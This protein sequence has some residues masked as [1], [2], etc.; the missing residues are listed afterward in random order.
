MP[1]QVSGLVLVYLKTKVSVHWVVLSLNPQVGQTISTQ[2]KIV[3]L[4]NTDDSSCT[5]RAFYLVN[6]ML[7][8]MI[9][10][11]IADT[12]LKYVNSRNKTALIKPI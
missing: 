4:K 3:F 7:S 6:K 8:I 11:P 5:P 2:I 9:M 12:N 1:G 10:S